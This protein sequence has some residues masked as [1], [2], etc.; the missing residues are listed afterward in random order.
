MLMLSNEKSWMNGQALES[1]PICPVGTLGFVLIDFAF[2]T[3]L[4]KTVPEG[5]PV[6]WEK[7]VFPLVVPVADLGIAKPSVSEREIPITDDEVSLLQNS[8]KSNPFPSIQL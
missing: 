7:E 1:N 3:T 5:E 8:P 4:F 6:H 2:L